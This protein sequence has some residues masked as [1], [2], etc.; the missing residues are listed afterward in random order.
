M[1]RIAGANGAIAT[2]IQFQVFHLKL[3]PGLLSGLRRSSE[4]TLA[5]SSEN[6]NGFTR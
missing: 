5:R 2:S 6:A 3:I 1:Q 4:R